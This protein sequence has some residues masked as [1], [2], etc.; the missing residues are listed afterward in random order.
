MLMQANNPSG[1]VC[2]GCGRLTRDPETDLHILR[3]AG[4][5][6]CCPERNM[7][8]VFQTNLTRERGLEEA[9][10]F[11]DQR[12]ADYVQEHGMTDPSTGTV[13]FPGWG[14]EYVDELENL[15]EGIRALSSQAAADGWLPTHRHKKRGTE[16]RIIGTAHIQCSDGL[17]DYEVVTIYVGQ[18]N[19]MWVR[20]ATEFEDGRFEA[21]TRSP[22]TKHDPH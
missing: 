12:I 22:R 1:F 5:V 17:T 14:D 18:D 16:Y 13:E 10:K 7:L 4:K 9:A 21:L 20:R 2:D 6:S 3:E 19:Q 8:P 11:I 15:A